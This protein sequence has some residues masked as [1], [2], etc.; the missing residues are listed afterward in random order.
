ML[1]RFVVDQYDERKEWGGK[2]KGGA[3]KEEIYICRGKGKGKEE[4]EYH[5]AM[6]LLQC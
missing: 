6:F 4:E 3:N 5:H 1:I 2:Q